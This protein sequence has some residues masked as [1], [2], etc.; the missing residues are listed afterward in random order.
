MGMSA[1]L[2]DLTTPLKLDAF[3]GD[4]PVTQFPGGHYWYQETAEDRRA[5]RR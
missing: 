3:G 1:V 4:E 5:E 2:R